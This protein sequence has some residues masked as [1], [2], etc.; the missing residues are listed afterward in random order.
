MFNDDLCCVLFVDLKWPASFD[1]DL[2]EPGLLVKSRI[3][4]NL[5]LRY[6]ILFCIFDIV[7]FIDRL[8]DLSIS[9]LILSMNIFISFMTDSR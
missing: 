3:L 9:M 2:V 8:H 5:A 7:F 4:D 1:V 6:S